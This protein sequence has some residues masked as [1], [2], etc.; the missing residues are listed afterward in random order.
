MRRRRLQGGG[1]AQVAQD[2]RANDLVGEGVHPNLPREALALK[3]DV[4]RLRPLHESGQR[5]LLEV[6]VEHEH[7]AGGEG[8][9]VVAV[10]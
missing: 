3:K 8:A 4:L 7:G 9:G 6:G 1:G 5:R 10:S 2:G